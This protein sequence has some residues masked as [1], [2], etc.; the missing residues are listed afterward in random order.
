MALAYDAI[1]IAM[2][3]RPSGGFAAPPPPTAYVD[4]PS[5][6]IFT[7][8]SAPPAAARRSAAAAASPALRR[9]GGDGCQEVHGRHAFWRRARSQ[10]EGAPPERERSARYFP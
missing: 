2:P 5:T 10:S 1:F 7:E 6:L 8:H 4:G 9:A 3:R